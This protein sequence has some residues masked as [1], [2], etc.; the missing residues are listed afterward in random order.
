MY[1]YNKIYCGRNYY[2]TKEELKFFR[3]KNKIT[4]R[5]L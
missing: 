3:N 5:E 1:L 4:E 2:K